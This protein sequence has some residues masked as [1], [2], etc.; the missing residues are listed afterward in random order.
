MKYKS[1]LKTELFASAYGTEDRS[2]PQR[3]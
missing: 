1:R 2:P 3:F